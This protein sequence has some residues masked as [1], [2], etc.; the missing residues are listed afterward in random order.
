MVYDYDDA[1]IPDVG[2]DET[3]L[4]GGDSGGPSF[5][6]ENGALAIV[7]I[8]SFHAFDSVSGDPVLSGDSFVP[9][10]IDELNAVMLRE[11][12]LALVPEPCTWQ[13]WILA[14]LVGALSVRGSRRCRPCAR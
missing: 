7:G 9:S 8:Y 5:V 11:E 13:L 3:F 4:V 2:A 6:V 1:D 10:Y 14:G 12:T